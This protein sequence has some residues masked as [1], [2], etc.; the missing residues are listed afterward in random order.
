MKAWSQKWK[1]VEPADFYL[2][3]NVC[4]SFPAS[5]QGQV[6]KGSGWKF[7]KKQLCE[8]QKRIALTNTGDRKT[9]HVRV[10]RLNATKLISLPQPLEKWV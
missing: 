5:E 8:G 9:Q 4:F 7:D 2:T 3:A 1:A 6:L 10:V